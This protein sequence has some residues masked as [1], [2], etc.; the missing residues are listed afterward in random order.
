[1]TSSGLLVMGLGFTSKRLRVKGFRV[2]A[3]QL[4]ER[5]LPALAAG[6]T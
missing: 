2:S 6:A 3:M 4:S 1:M 5:G